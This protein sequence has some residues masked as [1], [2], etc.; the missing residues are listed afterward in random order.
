MSFPLEPE[1]I[2]AKLGLHLLTLSDAVTEYVNLTKERACNVVQ[3]MD[4]HFKSLGSLLDDYDPPLLNTTEYLTQ[5]KRSMDEYTQIVWRAVMNSSEVVTFLSF[6]AS[7]LTHRN[8]TATSIQASLPLIQDT[9][10]SFFSTWTP[11]PFAK[12]SVDWSALS[13]RLSRLLSWVVWLDAAYRVLSVL[14]VGAGFSA[15]I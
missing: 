12:L 2:Y 7:S 8:A 4:G 6:F 11:R 1:A 14:R 15:Q 3:A 10:Y 9:V 13:A 5:F